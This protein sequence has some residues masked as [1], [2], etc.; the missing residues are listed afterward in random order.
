MVSWANNIGVKMGRRLIRV[1]GGENKKKG[2]ISFLDIDL[3]RQT[4]QTSYDFDY[5]IGRV[6]R[7]STE[8]LVFN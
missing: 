1:K 4:N 7:S 6:R 8:L 3:D 5:L 2:L